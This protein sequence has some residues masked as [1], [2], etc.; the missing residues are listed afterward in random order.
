MD[1][2][3]GDAAAGGRPR[4]RRSRRDS[5]VEFS[6]IVAF[7]DGVIAIAITLL[8]LNLEVPRVP[9]GDEGELADSLLDLLPHL[10]AYALS[11]AVIGRLWLIHHRFFAA[12]QGFDGRLMTAN[13]LY[14]A[15]IVLVPFSSDVLGTYGEIGVAVMVYAGTLGLAALVNLLMIRYAVRADLVKESERPVTEP[16]GSRGALLIPGAFILSLPIALLN[17]YAAQAV[18]VLALIGLTRQRRIAR[19]RAV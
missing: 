4:D 1:G 19:R 8:V 2:M 18:W 13:L 9:S 16:F 3:P 6:R 12:L 7:S 14:L 5:E 11:F 10:F 17:P 15:L